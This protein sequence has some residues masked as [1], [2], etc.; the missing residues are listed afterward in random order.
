MAIAGP[1]AC[2]HP[3][4]DTRQTDSLARV[5]VIVTPVSHPPACQAL[6]DT[7]R[8]EI[9]ARGP[10]SLCLSDSTLHP[11]FVTILDSSH[12]TVWLMGT[13]ATVPRAAALAQEDSLVVR[14]SSVL[15]P[16]HRCPYDS[17]AWPLEGSVLQLSLLADSDVIRP[18]RKWAVQLGGTLGRLAN[19]EVRTA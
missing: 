11:R 2:V 1:L 4:L 19:C 5:T 10:F 17:F 15:G 6:P 9:A 18:D 12:R 16:P 13:Y 14:L 7:I 8:F 3:R